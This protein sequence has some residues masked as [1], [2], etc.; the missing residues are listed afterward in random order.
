MH[1]GRA[2][3]HRPAKAGEAGSTP[4]RA[5]IWKR[6]RARLI[7]AVLKTAGPLKVPV[8]S[9]P[10]ASSNFSNPAVAELVSRHRIETPAMVV[11][12]HP[13]G[14][15]SRTLARMV[16]GHPGKVKPTTRVCGAGSNPAAS[17]I[18]CQASSAVERLVYTERVGG[19]NPSLGTISRA[20][21]GAVTRRPAK[22]K[23]TLTGGAGSIPAVPA[24]LHASDADT[25]YVPHRTVTPGHQ[26]HRE[27]ESHLAHHF[28]R[29][30]LA[31]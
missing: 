18:S 31:I 14:P 11:R 16:S 19:S 4:A 21:G 29:L 28:L 25:V 12:I 15:I 10:T 20:C 17:A 2:A 22:T 1:D 24:I 5:S 23:P 7:A 3:R 13:S 26:N 27:F 9:N 8:G 30:R 6:G